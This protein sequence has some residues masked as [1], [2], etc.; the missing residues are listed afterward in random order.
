MPDKICGCSPELLRVSPGKIVAVVTM[1]GKNVKNFI[2]SCL[3][4][5]FKINIYP[6]ATPYK[7]DIDIKLKIYE[8]YKVI[9]K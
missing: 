5:I 6:Y 8:V 2:L 4:S 1:N 9:Y 7:F 3:R